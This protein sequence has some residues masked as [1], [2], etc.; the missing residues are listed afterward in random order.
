MFTT[1]DEKHFCGNR[2]NNYC[3]VMQGSNTFIYSYRKR[4]SRWMLIL[5]HKSFCLSQPVWIRCVH[6]QWCSLFSLCLFLWF[7]SLWRLFCLP[8]R[9][10]VV[11]NQSCEEVRSHASVSSQDETQRLCQHEQTEHVHGRPVIQLHPIILCGF[12]HSKKIHQCH[13]RVESQFHHDAKDR[14]LSRTRNNLD[15]TCAR[16][17]K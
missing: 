9:Q 11:G 13:R 2:L 15:G 1:A 14:M 6:I 8:P 17:E 10:E 4:F 3:M 7:F 12:H 5:L 16:D